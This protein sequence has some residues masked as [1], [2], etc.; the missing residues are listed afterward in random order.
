M[1]PG[2]FALDAHLRPR[3]ELAAGW[4]GKRD[5]TTNPFTVTLHLRR[6]VWSDHRAITSADVRFSWQMLRSGPNGYRYRY[7]TDVQTPGPRTV[8]LRFEHPLRRWWA[9]FSL[10][11]MVLP[12]HAYSAAWRDGPTVSGGP[13]VFAGWTRGLKISLRRNPAYFGEKAHV[14]SIDVEFVPED[15]TRLKLLQRGELDAF[16]SPGDANMGRRAAAFGFPRAAEAL[17]GGPATSGAWAS[18]WWELDVDPARTGSEVAAAIGEAVDPALA[19]EIFEDSGQV[20]DGIPRRFP[21]PGPRADFGPA[22]PGPWAGR[23]DAGAARKALDAGPK[24]RVVNG[25]GTVTVSMAFDRDSGAAQIA[26]FVH[27]ALL[28]LRIR[29]DLVGLQSPD[30]ERLMAG[31]SAPPAVVWLRRGADAP[32]ASAYV[33]GRIGASETAGGDVTAAETS[34]GA[35]AKPLTGLDPAGWA[36]AERDLAASHTVYPLV[37]SRD[38]VVGRDLAGPLATGTSAGPLWNAATWRFG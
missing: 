5:V 30:L 1:L 10:D 4:P 11:D 13:F 16:F 32:D 15:E 26:G 20:A 9:L 28:P 38:W 19:A 21:A 31:P 6:A 12:A 7:L 8:R 33:F 23:G 36:A 25:G 2:L 18:A 37:R 35:V 27:F 22:L 3:P 14:S 17:D 34:G 24:G 29:T